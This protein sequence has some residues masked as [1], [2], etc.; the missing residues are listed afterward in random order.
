MLTT[1]AATDGVVRGRHIAI[2]LSVLTSIT[3]HGA[4]GHAPRRG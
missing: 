4:A 3:E 1:L 2:Q